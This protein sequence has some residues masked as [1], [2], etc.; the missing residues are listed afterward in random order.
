MFRI[1]EVKWIERIVSFSSSLSCHFL[2]RKL[3][4]NDQKRRQKWLQPSLFTDTNKKLAWLCNRLFP[5]FLTE[6]DIFIIEPRSKQKRSTYHL[7][8]FQPRLIVSR[9][10]S[11]N[12]H[13]KWLQNII[14]SNIRIYDREVI[15]AIICS[16]L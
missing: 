13:E 9:E 7:S 2:S 4:K 15:I 14:S 12:K 3:V 6:P 8:I 5:F 16:L 10:E 1:F 11:K